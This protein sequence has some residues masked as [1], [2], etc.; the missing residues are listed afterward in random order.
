MAVGWAEKWLVWGFLP[1]GTSSSTVNTFTKHAAVFRVDTDSDESYSVEGEYDALDV[2]VLVALVHSRERG[3]SAS[4]HDDASLAGA[5]GVED[6]FVCAYAF[7]FVLRELEQLFV[8]ADAKAKMDGD[9][10]H[11]DASVDHE[12][13]GSGRGGRTLEVNDPDD[14]VAG[15]VGEVGTGNTSSVDVSVAQGKSKKKIPNKSARRRT[16]D[17]E[18]TVSC[19]VCA[20]DWNECI[21]SETRER[22]LVAVRRAVREASWPLLVEEAEDNGWLQ[23]MLYEILCAT[24]L[25]TLAKF[26]GCQSKR[27]ISAERAAT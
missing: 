3:A 16:R 23:P 9:G 15:C 19:T 4:D 5:G 2:G 18:Q 27:F 25:S 10:S 6:A 7:A 13:A 12:L 26:L 8:A 1:S 20:T 21:Q 24:S 17:A 14:A 11:D 22:F